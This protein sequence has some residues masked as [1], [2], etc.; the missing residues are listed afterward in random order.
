MIAECAVFTKNLNHIANETNLISKG[1]TM[2]NFKKKA[3]CAAIGATLM[4]PATSLM[5][6]EVGNFFHTEGKSKLQI[7]LFYNDSKRDVEQKG[8]ARVSSGV[9][10]ETIIGEGETET[11][12]EVGSV[13][14]LKGEENTQD[15]YLKISYALTPKIE[16]YGKLG[17]SQT[18]LD[19][20]K[21]NWQFDE[22]TTETD[23]P[24]IFN[25]SIV[26]PL[27]ELE[28]SSR[29]GD[30]G[31]LAGVGTKITIHET[32]SGW[33]LG[34]DGQYIYRDQDMDKSLAWGGDL[35]LTGQE[36][37]ELQGSLILGKVV[38]N[39]RP[40]GGVSYTKY[41]S[42]YD[43]SE[44]GSRTGTI[45]LENEDNVG[46]FAGFDFDF[47]GLTASFEARGGDEEAFTFGLRMPL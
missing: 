33:N 36:S 20:D 11:T 45:D 47:S 4:V 5:A 35:E 38:G 2:N 27:D 9:A 7:G 32:G 44:G 24:D 10:T 1:I 34:L 16:V 25:T 6:A 18:D 31:W 30:R 23:N 41:E 17:A 43:L 46:Y 8:K 12:T 3:L 40:Y 37:H 13:S 22:S 14:G 39:F 26:E 15:L 42:E 21:A 19:I 29:G 28:T